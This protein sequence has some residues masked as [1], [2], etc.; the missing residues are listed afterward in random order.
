MD[1]EDGIDRSLVFDGWLQRALETNGG[2][3]CL[4]QASSCTTRPS[5]THTRT[6]ARACQALR[7][8][9]RRHNGRKIP[10]RIT[11]WAET[12]ETLSREGALLLRLPLMDWNSGTCDFT[13][14]LQGHTRAGGKQP[15]AVTGQGYR[16]S[17]MN[18]TNEQQTPRAGSCYTQRT[19]APLP[20]RVQRRPGRVFTFCI[21]RLRQPRR[22]TAGRA[23]GREAPPQS[24]PRSAGPS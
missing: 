6:G 21:F 7:T 18:G 19:P 4:P 1:G 11:P 17:A 24:T 22:R 14:G 5:R 16:S 3:Y 10:A 9:T 12:S 8:W 23:H 13:G 20:A 2:L 15:E